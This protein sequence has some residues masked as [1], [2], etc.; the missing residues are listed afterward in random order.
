MLYTKSIV[1][2]IQVLYIQKLRTTLW[3]GPWNSICKLSLLSN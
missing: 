2:V 3:T 1:K